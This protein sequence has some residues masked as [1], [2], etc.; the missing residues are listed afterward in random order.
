[1][2]LLIFLGGAIVGVIVDKFIS[3]FSKTYGVIEVDHNSKGCKVLIS[4]DD[5]LNRKN[6]KA[7]F[8][9]NHN[10]NFSREEQSL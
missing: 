3:I 7:I 8:S 4:S 1:M 9:I 6:K 2:E 10:A 5:L